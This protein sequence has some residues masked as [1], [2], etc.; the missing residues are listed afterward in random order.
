MRIDTPLYRR[1]D[2]PVGFS[3]TGPAIV[4]EY[5]STT[6]VAFGD[7]LEVGAL[8]ELRITVQPA[9]SEVTV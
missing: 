1:T 6:I 9:G 3:L 4:E 8:G 5:S 7:R 2:L